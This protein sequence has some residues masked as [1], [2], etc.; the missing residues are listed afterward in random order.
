MGKAMERVDESALKGA[1]EN[2]IWMELEMEYRIAS[3]WKYLGKKSELPFFLR[4]LAV[5][6]VTFE[7]TSNS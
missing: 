4:H 5:T 7:L 6:L 2:I 3:R 1:S